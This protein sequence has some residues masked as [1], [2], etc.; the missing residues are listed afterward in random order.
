MWYISAHDHCLPFCY[1]CP[2][3]S[4]ARLGNDAAAF[5]RWAW[6]VVEC[7]TLWQFVTSHSS[8]FAEE[9]PLS[10]LFP[11]ALRIFLP[12]GPQYPNGIALFESSLASYNCTFDNNGITN[13]EHW[14]NNTHGKNEVLRKKPVRV[15]FCSPQ[16]SQTGLGWNPGLHL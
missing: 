13:L 3:P 2:C 14:W 1:S 4:T 10:K 11:N 15:R 5:H 6:L 16:M 7:S 9:Q 12:N 8:L